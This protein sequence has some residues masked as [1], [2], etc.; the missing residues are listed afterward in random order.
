MP[1]ASS[2]PITVGGFLPLESAIALV[3]ADECPTVETL[4]GMDLK[5]PMADVPARMPIPRPVCSQNPTVDGGG[6]V[7]DTI[8][9]G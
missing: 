3:A 6:D 7:A 4:P 9:A 2:V 5:T 8:F 1:D